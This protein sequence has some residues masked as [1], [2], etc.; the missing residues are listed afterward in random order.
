MLKKVWICLKKYGSLLANQMWAFFQIWVLLRHIKYADLEW[1]AA[2]MSAPCCLQSCWSLNSTCCL[3]IQVVL[4]SWSHQHHL[5]V[6]MFLKLL[7]EGKNIWLYLHSQMTVQVWNVLMCLCYLTMTSTLL[8]W[9]LFCYCH[10]YWLHKHKST[11]ATA[12]EI[13][14]IWKLRLRCMIS[15]YRLKAITGESNCFLWSIT[16]FL[17]CTNRLSFCLEREIHVNWNDQSMCSR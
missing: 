12:V 6:D 15:V 14:S 2:D 13:P 10:L 17:Y 8:Y 11:H 7:Q 4:N 16:V 5:S 3:L 1:K 9:Y